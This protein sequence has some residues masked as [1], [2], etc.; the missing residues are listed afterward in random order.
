MAQEFSSFYGNCLGPDCVKIY[1]LNESSLY[2]DPNKLN[3]TKI[4]L[5][6]LSDEKFNQVKDLK[7]KLL[8]VFLSK[9]GLKIK[10]IVK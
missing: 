3:G 8:M 9:A 10:C 7:K 1:V 4:G 5:I 2:E 6:T